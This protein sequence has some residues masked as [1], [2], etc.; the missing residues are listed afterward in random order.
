MIDRRPTPHNNTGGSRAQ[1]PVHLEDHPPGAF[2]FLATCLLL[3]V[4]GAGSGQAAERM[5]VGVVAVGSA[6]RLAAD[7]FRFSATF[8]NCGEVFQ[9]DYTREG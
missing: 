8:F 3:F 6:E 1:A 2:S 4:V 7:Q 5:G 9:R